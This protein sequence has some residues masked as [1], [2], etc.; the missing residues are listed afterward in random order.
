MKKSIL[1]GVAG[2]LGVSIALISI[3]AWFYIR[4]PQVLYEGGFYT[5]IYY[6]LAPALPYLAT[7]TF[8]LGCL[9]FGLEYLERG[10]EELGK[11]GRPI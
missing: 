4:E 11:G 3:V 8:I 2:V 1:Y 5:V 10:R 7:F 9:S 6:P